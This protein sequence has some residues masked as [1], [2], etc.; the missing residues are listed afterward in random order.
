[1]RRASL[2]L[3]VVLLAAS[4]SC[5]DGTCTVESNTDGT[6]TITCDDGTSATFGQP[7]ASC[8][9][10]DNGDGT[11]TIT[12]DDGTTVTVG[13]D[14]ACTIADNDDGT[15]TITC[16]DGTTVTVNRP[17]TSCTVAD[18]GDGTATISCPDGSSVTVGDEGCTVSDNGDGTSTVSCDDGTSVVVGDEG[19]TITD[20]G[21]GT[22][23]ITCDDGTS[24]TVGDEGCTIADNG[25]GTSTI[26]CD[27][28]TSVTVGEDS[29]CTVVANADG[30]STVTCT[31]GTAVTV[32]QP[33]DTCT[34]ADNG[35]GTSTITCDDGTSVVVRQANDPCPDMT[36]SNGDGI[37]DLCPMDVL[38]VSGFGQAEIRAI[39]EGF[40]FTV[41]VVDGSTLGSSFDYSPYDV[42]AI[43]LSAFIDDVPR[44]VSENAAGRL[45]VVLHRADTHVD[46]FD[47]GAGATFQTG[48]FAI[49]DAGHYITSGYAVGALD[50]SFT[51]TSLVM[52]PTASARV[53]GTSTGPSLVVHR[54]HRRVV[55]PY[56]GNNVGFPASTDAA[57]LLWRSYIWAAGRTI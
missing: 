16:D 37:P 2:P 18:N 27:D 23:T 29:T 33:D 20:H 52:T 44:I 45:G 53:L 55:T 42:V 32:G 4:T 1:M 26:T 13:R 11:S 30:T 15:S 51:N 10:A 43:T 41:T 5:S 12:C 56:Y 38:L 21:D 57:V 54:T 14:D 47:I 19:C 34:V 40:G 46:D 49:A 6:S 9:I 24:V 25:D 39:L 17:D 48:S 36:D 31:D 3:F 7:D 50:L 28:G 35:D 22:S 8:T